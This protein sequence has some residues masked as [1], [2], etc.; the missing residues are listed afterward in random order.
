MRGNYQQH[1]DRKT[2]TLTS[3]VIDQYKPIGLTP[4][5]LVAAAKGR[6]EKRG[7]LNDEEQKHDSGIFRD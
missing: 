7:I 5:L 2:I 6:V 4:H 3:T 1:G